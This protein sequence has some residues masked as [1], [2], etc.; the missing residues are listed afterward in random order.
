LLEF[1][2]STTPRPCVPTS[3]LSQSCLTPTAAMQR[4]AGECLY[5]FTRIVCTCLCVILYIID[6]IC[7]PCIYNMYINAHLHTQVP[8]ECAGPACLCVLY[9]HTHTHTYTQ[10]HSPTHAHN[11]THTHTLIHAHKRTHTHIGFS[12]QDPRVCVCL[13]I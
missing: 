2:H 11:H 6:L 8:Q 3:Q 10:I 9:V 1:I 4:G 7:C 13:Y 5:V 12:A